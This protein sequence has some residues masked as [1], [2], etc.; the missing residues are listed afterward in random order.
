LWDESDWAEV[1]IMG[2]ED[3]RRRLRLRSVVVGGDKDVESVGMLG[4]R[5]EEG[6]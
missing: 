3:L 5:V 4:E 6:G 1:I 2:E